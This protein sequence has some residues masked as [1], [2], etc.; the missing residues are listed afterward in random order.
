MAS[1][2]VPSSASANGSLGDVATQFLLSLPQED[3]SKAQQEV[4]KFVRWY[5]EKQPIRGLTIPEVANYAEQKFLVKK[6]T[7][8]EKTQISIEVD[9][10]R[11]RFP[12]V[13]HNLGNY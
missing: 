2:K 5:G 7:H 10:V 8:K 3:R 9:E 11:L 12:I 4:Y 1:R 13:K 6:E